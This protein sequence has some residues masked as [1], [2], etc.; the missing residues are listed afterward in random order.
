MRSAIIWFTLGFGCISNA[1]I[2]PDLPS[3]APVAQRVFPQGAQRG[4][5]TDI[6]LTG[7]NL[8]DAQS[9]EFAGRG[10]NGKILAAFNGKL[11]LRVTVDPTAE[12]GRRD[13]R[14]TTLRGVYVGV[15]DIGAL[16]E[17][18]EV[19]PND[20]WHKPQSISMPVLVNG[21][22][23]NEDWD[24]FSVTA[25]AGETIVF[26]VSATRHGSRLDADL[27][28][29]DDQGRE[30]AWNDDTTVFG[31]P[32]LEY[33]F[34]KAGH[35]TVRVGSLSGGGNYRL[36]VGRLPYVRR[37]FPAGLTTGQLTTLTLTGPHMDLVDE[38]WIG[39]RSV[40][41]SILKKSA[42]QLK[43]SFRVPK[44]LASGPYLIHA[45][46]AG[47]EIALPTELRISSLPEITLASKPVSLQTAIP[48]TPS[49]VANGIIDQP[50]IAHY[51]RF[52]AKA[53]DTYMFR[54]ESMKLGYHL[55][56]TLILLDADGKKLAYADDPGVDERSDEYQLDTDL[57]YSFEKAGTYYVAI[58]DG[59]YRGG[60]Q[61]LYRLTLQRMAPDFILELREPVRSFYQGQSDSI[62]A[63]VRRR[64][65]WNTPVEVWAEDLPQGT[66]VERQTAAAKD[67]IVK[68][69]CG[70][71]RTV[72]GTIVSLPIHVGDDTA[73]GHS[74]FVVK[75]R[76]VMNGVTV[77]HSAVVRYQNLSAGLT[78][79]PMQQQRAQLTIAKAPAVVLN[80]PDTVSIA[81][82]DERKLKIAVRRFGEL[83]KQTL[84]IQPHQ[85]PAG[86]SADPIA[87]PVSAKNIEVIVKT[88]TKAVSTPLVFEVISE[89][90]RPVGQSPPVLF[91]IK[92]KTQ[93][94]N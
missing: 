34:A 20:D 63:R 66:E 78:Y 70:V 83:K 38:V 49:L 9:I 27:A 33:T 13:F 54:A 11:K 37:T 71:D 35:Y 16:P 31:D 56:P 14:L 42:D 87:V 61:L 39:D 22:L 26:D 21:V 53:G 2:D 17:I 58:R 65:G 91:E 47:H 92:P 74:D 90:N 62:Q 75:A 69:T 85:M 7:E 89:D 86:F 79:G 15:F 59:M 94:R 57:S 1:A 12:V 55:D 60:D 67:S 36:S 68:D 24:H 81:P 40:R 32:H 44:N 6:E 3:P 18:K 77:E 4:T 64:A 46:H 30:L 88:N 28:V 45:S 73:S 10:V 23:G 80:L 41:G 50:G 43:A 76:G 48:V 52:A 51:F 5:T 93:V 19:E 8:H 72:D 29:L 82:G 25:A 84:R